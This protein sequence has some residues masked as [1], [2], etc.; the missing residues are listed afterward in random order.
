[1]KKEVKEILEKSG[2]YEGRKI[3]IDEELKDL[4]DSGLFINEKAKD[5]LREFGNLNIDIEGEFLEEKNIHRHNTN[6]NEMKP[7]ITDK[8]GYSY[9]RDQDERR[10]KLELTPIIS[11]DN[12]RYNIYISKEGKCYWE[13]NF[14]A[15]N[16]EKAWERLFLLHL[17]EEEI[18]I[19]ILEKAGWYEGRDIDITDMV[20]YMEEGNLNNPVNEKAKNFLKQFGDLDINLEEY[21]LGK[22]SFKNHNTKAKQLAY[23][24]D[25]ELNYIENYKKLKATPII[26]AHNSYYDVFISEEG[27]YYWER[28][29]YADNLEN[30]WKTL[31]GFQMQDQVRIVCKLQESGWYKDR[32]INI[33][34]IIYEYEEYGFKVFDKA[35]MFLKEYGKLVIDAHFIND[36]ENKYIKCS[37][38]TEEILE[39]FGSKE[40][41]YYNVSRQMLP[42]VLVRINDEDILIYMSLAGEFYFRG[43][44]FAENT[45][46]LWDR[47]II[48][49]GY[50]LE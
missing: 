32:N 4:E 46:F 20:K 11:V 45:E 13:N 19:N 23:T 33:D 37:L 17:E 10:Q 43:K 9:I 28:G 31:F 8:K 7:R 39:A 21:F 40:Q 35:K 5:F 36:D 14:F 24:C 44:M 29:E 22:K 15:E 12:E 49:C 30:M 18:I 1:M 25:E 34:N 50:I 42:V 48:D 6:L 16:V 27:K 3:N 38:V 2:W 41:E 47:L 26:D